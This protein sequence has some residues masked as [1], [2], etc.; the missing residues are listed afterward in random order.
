MGL[1]RSLT[2][3]LRLELTSADVSG[4]LKSISERGIRLTN[5]QLCSDLTVSF[6]V[7]RRSLGTIEMMAQRRGERL[8]ILG[9]SGIFWPLSGLRR[10]TFLVFGTALL[11]FLSLFVPSRVLF[12]EVE[13]NLRVP[14]RKILEAAADA[15][16]G[17]GASRRAVRSE[18]MKN[19]LLGVLPQLQWA[20]VNTYGCRA[21]ITVR[22]REEANHLAENMAVS[23]I[24]AVCDGVITSCTVTG[25]GALCSVGQAV[26]KGQIL[27]SGYVDCGQVITATRAQGEVFARTM[28]NLT[29]LTPSQALQ[30]GD[31]REQRTNYSLQVGKKRINFMKGSGI[32]EGT[33]VKM[34]SEYY[35]TL[36]G[37]YRLP[38][39]LV[40]ETV[41]SFATQRIQR[42]PAETEQ[43]LSVFAKSYL[44]DH[45]V[46]LT[47][48]D[49]KESFSADA[50][51]FRLTGQYACT[52]MI[53]REQGEQIGD[54]HG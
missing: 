33:C 24:V 28:H 5:V 45:M 41:L 2:G 27:I 20:G 11:F 30:R 6:T 7:S 53:G 1:F 25:G 31:L 34:Y 42:S 54:S 39:K 18:K 17:F 10:R 22:E 44:R 23:S 36:P 4:T 19:A 3:E 38:V 29:V 8:R 13:G 37:D 51:A 35:I 40:K 48:L 12:V 52:E 14:E 16:I 15:G 32:S 50:A 43:S 9:R 26:R 47:V 46:A 49:A 21:V